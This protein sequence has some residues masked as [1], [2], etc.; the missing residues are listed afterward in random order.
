MAAPQVPLN[1]ALVG[2]IALGCLVAGG[3]WWAWERGEA[4]GLWPGAFLRVGLVMG[5]FWLAMPTHTRE[6]AWAR[7]SIWNL[8]GGIAAL[9]VIARTKFPIKIL[10]PGLMIL[11]V[12]ILVLRPR[13]KARPRG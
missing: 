11:A 2:C 5:A 7:V 1:R 3:L 12:T 6:A 8:I 13:P 10:I 4:P 9:V